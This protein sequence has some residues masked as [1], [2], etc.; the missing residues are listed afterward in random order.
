MISQLA[1]DVIARAEEYDRLRIM[2]SQADSV[3]AISFL[4]DEIGS[5]LERWVIVFPT[6]APLISL[7]KADEIPLDAA[8][9]AKQLT[10]SQREFEGHNFQQAA[11]KLNL[12]KSK[13][14]RLHHDTKEAWTDYA[15]QQVEPL[16]E[17]VQI[18]ERLPKMAPYTNSIHNELA[19]LRKYADQMPA[20]PETVEQFHAHLNQLKAL[21][22][23]L[24][25]LP[26]DVRTFVEKLMKGEATFADVTSDVFDWCHSEG[27]A[28]KLRFV[29]L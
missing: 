27:L 4:L 3:R 9:I 19:I 21:V 12:L 8:T 17:L 23:D 11:T 14:D 13:I 22:N 26:G 20:K 6:I 16:T 25:G 2:V 15:Y 1:G 29:R 7:E 28:D 18:A 5:V 10:N 24:D